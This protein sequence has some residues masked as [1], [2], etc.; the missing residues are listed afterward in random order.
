MP[1]SVSRFSLGCPCLVLKSRQTVQRLS[2]CD[3]SSKPPSLN[4]CVP[5]KA[6][7]FM[8]QESPHFVKIVHI[9]QNLFG[10]AWA[11]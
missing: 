10:V 6:E 11:G 5:L 2:N 8:P 7:T 9:P 3:I 1:A 4:S